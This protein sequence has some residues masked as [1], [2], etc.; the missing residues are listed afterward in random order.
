MLIVIDRKELKNIS[1]KFKKKYDFEYRLHF[2]AIFF[3]SFHCPL[4]SII[5][6][7][8][9]ALIILKYIGQ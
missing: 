3:G 6:C 1:F 8:E 5:G 4:L 2:I 7:K 9:L